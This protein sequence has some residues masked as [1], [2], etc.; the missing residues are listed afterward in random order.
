MA[1][2]SSGA[3]LAN[4]GELWERRQQF[5]HVVQAIPHDS[6][7]VKSA[8]P[9]A[10]SGLLLLLMTS[11]TAFSTM[12]G[13]ARCTAI[14]NGPRNNLMDCLDACV[15]K[16]GSEEQTC[17]QQC[18][19]KTGTTL[20]KVSRDEEKCQKSTVKLPV[21]MH[22]LAF[23]AVWTLI[24]VT[25]LLGA[26]KDACHCD[27]CVGEGCSS[28][29]AFFVVSWVFFGFA[30]LWLMDA[31]TEGPAELSGKVMYGLTQG[32]SILCMGASRIQAERAEVRDLPGGRP[33]LG[34]SVL[35]PGG[36]PQTLGATSESRDTREMQK[37]IRELNQQVAWLMQSVEE[38]QKRS[39]CLPVEELQPT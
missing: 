31:S 38:L 1:Q 30:C 36:E 3:E 5:Q 10:V 9:M 18:R 15:V 12:T 11:M 8:I 39:L 22:I 33:L 27:C 25:P 16:P 4:L 32:I 35:V 6:P 34:Q 14:A 17:R 23:V 21:V 19:Q 20:D 26:Y 13:Q 2:G 29:L 24:P 28:R 7:K 37:Q